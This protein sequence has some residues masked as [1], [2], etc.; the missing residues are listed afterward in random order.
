[1]KNFHITYSTAQD[2]HMNSPVL[3]GLP[4]AT[5]SHCGTC[6]VTGALIR[7]S[8]YTS[9]Q[10][11]DSRTS[12]VISRCSRL[13]LMFLLPPFPFSLSVT[14]QWR[15]HHQD[16]PMAPSPPTLCGRSPFPFFVP[17]RHICA[18]SLQAPLVTS[19]GSTAGRTPLSRFGACRLGG[20][21]V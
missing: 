13:R 20:R 7:C 4:A 15:P 21:H 2:M 14:R 12:T 6:W 18:Q 9:E 16:T 19:V 11:V 10:Q 8:S 3:H 5:Q 17:R 1:M